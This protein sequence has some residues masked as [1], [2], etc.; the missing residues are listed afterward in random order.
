MKKEN[1][2]SDK[3]LSWRGP[4]AQVSSKYCPGSP[5][6]DRRG[7]LP[8]VKHDIQRVAAFIDFLHRM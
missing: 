3:Q 1:V 8:P 5:Q 2:S 4:R 7:V 6:V